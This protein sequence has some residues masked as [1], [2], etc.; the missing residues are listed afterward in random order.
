MVLHRRWTNR[1]HKKRDKGDKKRYRRRVNEKTKLEEIVY[2]Y[3]KNS[4]DPEKETIE[5]AK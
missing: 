4:D 5:I 3:E 2:E 1:R